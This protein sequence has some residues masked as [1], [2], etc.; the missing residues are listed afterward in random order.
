M[1][2]G[3]VDCKG[4]D[5]GYQNLCIHFNM[6]VMPTLIFLE[7]GKDNYYKYEGEKSVKDL[8]EFTIGGGYKEVTPYSVS[9][10][11]SLFREHIMPKANEMFANFK[12]RFF[13]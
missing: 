13:Q 8:E 6:T 9:S 4:S 1:N 7:A 2:L 3:K 12:R 5:Y 10:P 11:P